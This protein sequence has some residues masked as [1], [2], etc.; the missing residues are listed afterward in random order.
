MSGGGL[1]GLGLCCC[2]ADSD[3]DTSD[4]SVDEDH[5]QLLLEELT[6]LQFQFEVKEVCCWLCCWAQDPPGGWWDPLN[7]LRAAFRSSWS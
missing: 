5:Q 7:L 2:L 4:K 3:E 6:H 1:D